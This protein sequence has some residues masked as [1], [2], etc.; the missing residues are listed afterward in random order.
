MAA[1]IGGTALAGISAGGEA[2]GVGL[3]ATG[4]GALA[5]VPLN[6]VSAAGIVTGSGI[7]AA[8]LNSLAQ[9]AAARTVSRP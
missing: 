5:G 7:A 9:N 1:T 8:G 6:V 4:V 2:L 3:D